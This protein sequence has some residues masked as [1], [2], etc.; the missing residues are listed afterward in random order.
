MAFRTSFCDPFK[1]DVVELGEVEKD[2]I[3]DSFKRLPMKKLLEEMKLKNENEIHFSPSFEVENLENKNGVTASIVD[4][5][6]WYIF[7]KRPKMVKKYFGLVEKIDDNFTTEI[8]GQSEQDV[9]NC[10]NALINNDL[11]FLENKIK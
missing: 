3:I 6:E 9:I 11:T 5:K 4:E 2:K 8:L 10:L 1:P 7:Y